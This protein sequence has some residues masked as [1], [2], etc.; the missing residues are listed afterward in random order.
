MFADTPITLKLEQWED[1]VENV[2]FA[3]KKKKQKNKNY[4]VPN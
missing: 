4:C 2:R 1:L 3:K